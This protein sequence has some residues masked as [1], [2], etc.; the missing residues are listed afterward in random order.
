MGT[1]RRT[2]LG[3][4]GLPACRLRRCTRTSRRP[5]I[6]G[7]ATRVTRSASPRTAR[8]RSAA[9]APGTP[10]RPGWSWRSTRTTRTTATRRTSPGSPTGCV[11]I[12][13][14]LVARGAGRSPRAT[15]GLPLFA[16]PV[17][18]DPVLAGRIRRAA[19][20]PGRRRV[21][22]APGRAADRRRRRDGPPGPPAAVTAAGELT[23]GRVAAASYARRARDLLQAAPLTDISAAA[24]R[25]RRRVQPVRPAP[26]VRRG[27][28][29]DPGGLPAADP[30]AAG[31]PPDRGRLP[32][33]R[34]GRGVGI[35]GSEPPDALV[36]P[37]LR[38]HARRLPAGCPSGPELSCCR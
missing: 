34:R 2:G 20:R 5:S 31:P 37:A 30:A 15:A 25:G 24:A 3:T 32:D 9:G 33:Q 19:P 36:R 8:S 4:G 12:G 14:E 11:H 38:D 23:G 16:E 26:G 10:A 17:H 7:T 28:R 29:P 18:A 21:R 35:R 22:A 1:W 27:L 6:T 13:T